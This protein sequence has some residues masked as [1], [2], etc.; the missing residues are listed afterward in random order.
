[1]I[2]QYPGTE[3]VECTEVVYRALKRAWVKPN[4][5]A[6]EAFIRRKTEPEPEQQISLSR[7]KYTTAREC[8]SK[9]QKMPGVA[10]LHVG[11][12]RDLEYSLDVQPDPEPADRG[13]CLLTNL[14]HPVDDA[15]NAEFVAS[16]LS[17]IARLVSL[18][19]EEREH[20]DRNPI[21]NR[22]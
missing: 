20:Q 4:G 1:M 12:V 9:L 2:E 11:R 7:Q 15:E 5:V 10:S 6:P 18:E 21:T 8:R 22:D 17:R 14:P 16:Q 13:H 19:Q 3:E